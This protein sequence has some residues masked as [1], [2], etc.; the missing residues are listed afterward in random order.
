VVPFDDPRSADCKT[1]IDE[2]IS[3]KLSDEVMSYDSVPQ[4]M[5]HI[6]NIVGPQDRI[7]VT[8][9]FLTVGEAIS[10]LNLQS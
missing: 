10:Y 3:M 7:V 4:A 9:S 2:I 1:I 5:D 8:G 6:R